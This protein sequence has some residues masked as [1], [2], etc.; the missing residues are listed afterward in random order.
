[1]FI[2]LLARIRM[3]LVDVA[4]PASMDGLWHQA[5]LVYGARTTFVSITRQSKTRHHSLLTGGE[6]QIFDQ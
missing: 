1:M 4:Q 6:I 5:L 3:R 2:T